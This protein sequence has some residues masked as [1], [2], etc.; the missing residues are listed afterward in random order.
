MAPMIDAP[1]PLPVSLVTKIAAAIP[2]AMWDA[3]RVALVGLM[4][5]TS[6]LAKSAEPGRHAEVPES[7]VM[8]SPYQYRP[9]RHDRPPSSSA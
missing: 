4:M 1:M 6:L 7:D 2:T 5:S 3:V 9:V 8:N